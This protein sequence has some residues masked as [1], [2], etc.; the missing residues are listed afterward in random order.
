MGTKRAGGARA[1]GPKRQSRE[2][3]YARGAETREQIIQAA[4]EVFSEEGYLGASTRLI[5]ARAGVNPP[6]LQYYFD[7]KE[8]L[9]E[10]CGRWVLE[11]MRGGFA[12]VLEEAREALASGRRKTVI[13][14][15]QNLLERMADLTMPR[16]HEEA[17][18]RF[19][20]RSKTE[21]SGPPAFALIER[22]LTVP[23]KSMVIALVAQAMG[24][25]KEDERARIRALLVLGQLWGVC[26]GA[27]QTLQ[28]LGWPDFAGDRAA[29]IQ[30]LLR[31]HVARLFS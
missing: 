22:E 10:A 28:D 20:G 5:A 30:E 6:A 23:V 8:G 13:E 25:E 21:A 17:W 11:R 27:D 7:S 14:A 2:G 12:P 19:F 26:E 15:L 4:F 24:V 31:E 9:H 16:S 18:R 3:G 29:R 1:A